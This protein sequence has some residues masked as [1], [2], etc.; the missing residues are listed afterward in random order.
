MAHKAIVST[1]H[2]D[3][4]DEAVRVGL[5][6]PFVRPVELSGDRISDVDVLTHALKEM[7]R[8]DRVYNWIVMLQP[9]SPLRKVQPVIDTINKLLMCK[10]DSVLTVSETDPKSH[11]LKQLRLESERVRYF[12]DA[13]KTIIARQQLEKL[14][15]RNGVAYGMTRECLLDQKVVIGNICGSVLIHEP[16]ISIDTPLDLAYANW[17]YTNKGN[18]NSDI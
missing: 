3:I 13:G 5:E 14:F 16:V 12:D 8:C 11:P 2:K 6:V 18:I 9:T 7:E 17:L 10:Y 4:A 15:H 1:D